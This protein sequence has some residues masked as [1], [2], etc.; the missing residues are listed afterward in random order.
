MTAPERR[1]RTSLTRTD[2]QTSAGLELLEILQNMS[3]DGRL[4]REECD[5]LRSWLAQNASAEVAA[6]THL[7]MVIDEVLNDGVV[8]DDE[9]A[10]LHD[11]VLRVLPVDLRSIA[12]LR[13]REQKAAVR[14]ETRQRKAEEQDRQRAERE[15]NSPL[16]R[17][18]FMVAGASKSAERREACE[19]CSEGDSVL[20]E[21]EPD[22]R[23][24]RNA[25]VIRDS[26]G[27][28]LGYVPREVAES[29]A[30]LM[31]KGAKQYFTIKKCLETSSG[32]I[33]PVVCGA[34]YRS[35]ADALQVAD[36]TAQSR[37]IAANN[38]VVNVPSTA[39]DV[40]SLETDSAIS[41]VFAKPSETV[42]VPADK[43]QTSARG[44]LWVGLLVLLALWLLAFL[45]NR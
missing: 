14:Q 2:L 37:P 38:A 3:R 43:F 12:T 35:D 30:A 22:N 25:I 19:S 10:V 40:S 13:R 5:Q 41:S 28:E 11:A 4:T 1:P 23:H 39:A 6:S 15:R 45:V 33:I 8:T 42:T 34:F 29:Y 7:K 31:D 36:R 32:R 24:D 17:A 44:L 16:A 18:D 9:L 21:R 20:L 27:E 26:G